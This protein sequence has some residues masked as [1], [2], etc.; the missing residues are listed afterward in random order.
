[1][2]LVS[3]AY[4]SYR[5]I[6]AMGSTTFDPGHFPRTHKFIGLTSLVC[7]LECPLQAKKFQI[8]TNKAV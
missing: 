4:T 2:P 3:I 5:L 8:N 1:M 6:T 7:H